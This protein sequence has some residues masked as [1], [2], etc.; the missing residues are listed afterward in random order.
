[1]EVLKWI[2]I[3]F[4]ICCA[5]VFVIFAYLFRRMLFVKKFAE[6]SLVANKTLDV[7]AEG[8]KVVEIR[9][10]QPALARDYRPGVG[11]AP[12]AAQ[13]LLTP[14]GNL[15]HGQH[16]FDGDPRRS[17]WV[18]S[19]GEGALSK[20]L[21]DRRIYVRESDGLGPQLADFSDGPFAGFWYAG[22]L[23]KDWFLVAGY[24]VGKTCGDIALWQVSHSDYSTTL[25]QTNL[26]YIDHRP[27]K[28]FTPVGFPGVLVAIYVD[29]VSYG[30]GGYCNEPRYSILR[31]Y[32]ERFPA[33]IDL[34]KLSL[35]GGVIVA[36]EWRD[37]VL[38][39]TADP[40]RPTGSEGRRPPRIW[41]ID[42]PDQVVNIHQ[43][44]AT[45][46]ETATAH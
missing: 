32:T 2:G 15:E 38:W 33:G 43:S 45:A 42:L 13:M 18:L 21:F 4:G 14:E 5:V 31:A 11:D 44:S 17:V 26:Y 10:Q 41:S 27:P 24:P 7:L 9:H 6:R 19:G 23:N 12:E 37:G 25:L 46:G 35:K 28:I 30:F 16:V 40:S 36:V 34:V 29:D 8:L 1:M 22:S 3:G 20:V 39:V